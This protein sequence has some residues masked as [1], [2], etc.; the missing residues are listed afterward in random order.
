MHVP[1]PATPKHSPTGHPS[2]TKRRRIGDKED[3]E[4]DSPRLFSRSSPTAKLPEEEIEWVI[5]PFTLGKRA[6]KEG[7]G[8]WEGMSPQKKGRVKT[9]DPGDSEDE[10]IVEALVITSS[11]V[12]TKHRRVFMDSV[13]VPRLQDVYP[14]LRSTSSFKSLRELCTPSSSPSLSHHRGQSRSVPK[15]SI[16]S[17]GGFSR[18]RRRANTEDVF[19]VSKTSCALSDSESES[20][21]EVPFSDSFTLDRRPVSPKEPL[22]SDDDPHI[23]QVTPHRLIS[24]IPRRNMSANFCDVDPPSDDSV[25]GECA[26]P[27]KEVVER[28]L[29]RLGPA[30]NMMMAPHSMLTKKN[31]FWS[32]KA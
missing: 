1:T 5:K 15:T 19:S 25:M 8:E 23:G 22:S 28:R 9:I 21:P 16:S 7:N 20:E 14:Q 32:I 3:K 12:L 27:S 13:S 17:S 30:T 10:R 11:P 4:N 2:P 29:K 18:K 24:P 6:R 26:S 31:A